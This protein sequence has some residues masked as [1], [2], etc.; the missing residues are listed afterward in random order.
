MEW[1]RW[2]IIGVNIIGLVLRILVVIELDRSKVNLLGDV[3][4]MLMHT[5]FAILFY[6]K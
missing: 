1:L 5:V 2:L 6:L 4:I 3:F